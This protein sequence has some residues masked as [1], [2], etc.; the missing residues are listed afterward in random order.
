MHTVW[1]FK[2]FSVT[3]ILGYGRPMRGTWTAE[4]GAKAHDHVHKVSISVLPIN[5]FFH[6]KKLIWRR[7]FHLMDTRLW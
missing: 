5:P 3:I 1:N 2:D 4:R 7:K 6:I